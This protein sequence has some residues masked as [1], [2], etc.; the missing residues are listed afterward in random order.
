MKMKLGKLVLGLSLVFATAATT[1]AQ[2]EANRE[3]LRMRKIANDAMGVT[4]YKEAASYF[5]KG[6]ELCGADFGKDNYTRLISCLVKVVNAEKDAA[7]KK[8]YVDTLNMAYDKSEAAEAYDVKWDVKRG[9]FATQ[10]SKPNYTKADEF[11]TRG[12][13]RD[14]AEVREMYI[15]YYYYNTYSMWYMAQKPEKKAE[16]KQRIIKDYF[17]LSGIVAKANYSPKAQENLNGYLNSVVQSCDDLLPEVP[18]FMGGLP[19][20]PEAK[21]AALMNMINL[22]E[23]KKCGT[24]KEFSGLI[25]SYLELDPESP[26]A[27]KLKAKNDLTTGNTASGISTLKKLKE[28]A[29]TDEEKQ[30]LQYEIA[31]A[32]FNTGQYGSAYNAAMAVSGAHKGDALAIAGQCVGKTAMNSGDSTFERKCNYIY[33][34]QLLQQAQAN[35]ASGVGG[36][37]NSYKGSYPTADDCFNNGNPASQSLSK[38]GVT[39]QPCK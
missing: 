17:K 37:I 28:L 38:W 34:V 30:D 29:E 19:E 36:V 39:V 31:R 20:D 5:L 10:G 18:A 9:L 8:L 33:A 23:D 12:I 22:M 32:Y 35:G 27:L 13:D 6:E 16:L 25:S 7:Q 24:S 1:H 2:D 3:C 14:G 21:K 4:N 26:T 11:Y 15:S